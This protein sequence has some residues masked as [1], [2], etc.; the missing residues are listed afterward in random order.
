MNTHTIDGDCYHRD[1]LKGCKCNLELQKDACQ[2]EEIT[3]Q[4]YDAER[5][6]IDAAIVWRKSFGTPAGYERQLANAVSA[7]LKARGP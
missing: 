5:A 7:L 4:Q 6:V 2:Y 1:G 3:A